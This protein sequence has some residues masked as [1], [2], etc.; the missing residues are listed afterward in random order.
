MK[1][2]SSLFRRDV[3]CSQIVNKLRM[4]TKHFDIDDKFVNKGTRVSL[5]FRATDKITL[6]VQC[7]GPN[8]LYCTVFGK[9]HSMVHL[10]HFY[11]F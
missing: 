8:L 1:R 9:I 2:W 5:N 3:Q 6:L 10:Q 11:L 4:T 7:L